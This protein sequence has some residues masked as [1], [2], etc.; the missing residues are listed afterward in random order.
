[1]WQHSFIIIINIILIT[2]MNK[3]Q[4]LKKTK[5]MVETEV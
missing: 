3:K 2:K 1:M 5:N 4:K